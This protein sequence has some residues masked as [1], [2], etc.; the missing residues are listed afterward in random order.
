MN[1]NFPAECFQENFLLF[2]DPHKTP[3]K[4]NLYKGLGHLAEMIATILS[5]VERLEQLLGSW[6][7]HP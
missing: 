3:E 5:K 6:P 4:Y 1:R 2:S 7:S